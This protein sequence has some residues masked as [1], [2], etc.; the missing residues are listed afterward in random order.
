[1]IHELRPPS[2]EKPVGEPKPDRGQAV[3]GPDGAGREGQPRIGSLRPGAVDTTAIKAVPDCQLRF[4]P[5][6]RA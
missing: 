4:S 1:M 6:R 2:S 5:V 3:E